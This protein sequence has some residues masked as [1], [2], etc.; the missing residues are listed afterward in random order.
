[1]LQYASDHLSLGHGSDRDLQTGYPGVPN[2]TSTINMINQFLDW[3]QE[4][5][6]VWIVSTIQLLDWVR[7]PVPV[8]QLNSLSSFQCATPV[9]N[10]KICNGVPANEAGLL[11]ACD[12]SAFPFFTCYGCPV[13]PPTPAD[14]NPSQVAVSG[15]YRTRLA[16]DCYTAFWDP[17]NGTCLCQ[18]GTSCQ[19]QDQTRPIGPN[20]ANLTGGGTGNGPSTSP[21]YIPFNGGSGAM[22]SVQL[23]ANVLFS[24]ALGLVG[25]VLGVTSTLSA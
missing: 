24:I 20:G 25:V 4:Q 19:F 9:V 22:P 1:M 8:S 23:S 7:N 3:A 13:D 2:P 15:K 14:P 5:S 11:D 6:N 18:N 21:T 17:I 10:A 16:S 12:F